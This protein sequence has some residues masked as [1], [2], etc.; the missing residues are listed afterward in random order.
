M[1]KN[2][3][4]K[5]FTFIDL[6]AGIGG[7]RIGMEAVGG[8]CVWSNDYDKFANQTYNHWFK[9]EINGSDINEAINENIIP[10]HDILCGGFPCQHLVMLGNA[11]ALKMQNKGIYSSALKRLSNNTNQRSY[12]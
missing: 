6:F 12:F 10:A 7:F 1:P 2:K 8:K 4:P 11:K 9:D 5:N 3:L